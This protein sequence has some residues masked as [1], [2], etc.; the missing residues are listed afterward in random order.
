[1]THEHGRSSPRKTRWPPGLGQVPP[2]RVA[3]VN[4]FDLAACGA[5]AISFTGAC[6]PGQRAPVIGAGKEFR[7][8]AIAGQLG[9]SLGLLAASSGGGQVQLGGS[10]LAAIPVSSAVGL[11]GRCPTRG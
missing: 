5:I 10:Y 11:S 7:K 1:M 3:G 6:L 8:L 9:R 4:G 2:A